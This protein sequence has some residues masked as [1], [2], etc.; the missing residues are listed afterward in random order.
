VI[1]AVT[2]ANRLTSAEKLTRAQIEKP[3][4]FDFASVVDGPPALSP[5]GQQIAFVAVK[6]T[7]AQIFFSGLARGKPSR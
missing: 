1:F 7:K 2:Y 6:D 5:D 3:A 4:G